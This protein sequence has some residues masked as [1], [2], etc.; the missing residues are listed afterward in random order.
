MYIVKLS[1]TDGNGDCQFVSIEVEGESSDI[2]V[3]KS[4][5]YYYEKYWS[6]TCWRKEEFDKEMDFFKTKLHDLQKDLLVKNIPYIDNVISD[7][8][9]ELRAKLGSTDKTLKE[10]CLMCIDSKIEYL[11]T[12]GADL[13]Y[14]IYPKKSKFEN[15]KIL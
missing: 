3:R 10:F 11:S 4:I 5:D 12:I 2:A 1:I 7:Y 13:K 6:N 8:E 15:I 14:F 9:H